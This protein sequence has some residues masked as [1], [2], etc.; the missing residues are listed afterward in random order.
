MKCVS[1]TMLVIIRFD[2][3]S[4]CV[5]YDVYSVLVCQAV[6]HLELRRVG[7]SCKYI[8]RRTK[9]EINTWQW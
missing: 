4:C 5:M 1:A 2:I 8:N 3:C 6:S 7:I 9:D